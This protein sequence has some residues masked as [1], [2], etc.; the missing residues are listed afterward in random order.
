MPRTAKKHML[1]CSIRVYVRNPALLPRQPTL[2]WAGP[3]ADKIMGLT[4]V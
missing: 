2:P 3:G 4:G 1:R